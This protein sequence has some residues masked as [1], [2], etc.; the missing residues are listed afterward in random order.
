MRLFD[1]EPNPHWRT[2][3][4]IGIQAETDA[5]ADFLCDLLNQINSGKAYITGANHPDG[6]KNFAL[7]FILKTQ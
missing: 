2:E 7:D 4:G 6:R 1:I 3:R 5:E